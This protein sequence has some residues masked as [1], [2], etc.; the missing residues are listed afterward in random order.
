[1]TRKLRTMDLFAGAEGFIRAGFESV[2]HAESNK[3]GCLAL[4]TKM[5][6]PLKRYD[7]LEYCHSYFDEILLRR[8]FYG[9]VSDQSI[10]SAIWAE[11]YVFEVGKQSEPL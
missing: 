10:K 7:C 1:M 6:F 5:A 2:A 11:I 9:F 3:V 8:E 4:C